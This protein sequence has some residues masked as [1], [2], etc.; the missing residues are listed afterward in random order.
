MQDERRKMSIFS[1]N[2]DPMGPLDYS[3][4]FSLRF[5]VAVTLFFLYAPIIGRSTT[6]AATSS[7]AASRP[8]IT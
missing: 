1:R 8:T 6:A 5:T 7:G 3:R 2:P 4:R